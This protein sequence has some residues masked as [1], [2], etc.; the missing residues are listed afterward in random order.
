[1]VDTL[2]V[3]LLKIVILLNAVLIAVTYMVLL[4]RKVI[5]WVQS[6]LGPMR[7]G[8]YGAL[9]PIADAIKLMTKEDITPTRADRWV[10]TASPI[11]VMVPA[12]IVFAVIPFGPEVELFGRSVPL[13]ITDIN[14]GLLYIVSVASLGVYGII[15][16]G[17]SSNSKYPLLSSL[18][19]SAQLISYEVAVT[20]T[21]VSMILMAGTLSMVGIVE[22]QREAGLWFAFVQPVAFVIFFIGGLA[23]TNR[24]PFDLPEAEQELTGGFHTEYSGMRFALFFLAEYANMIVISCL[25]VTLFL[26]GWLRPF[27]SVEALSF[28]DLVPSWIWFLFKTFV[29]LYIFLWIRATL[30]RYRYDQLMR[31]GWKVLIPIAIGNVVVTG[32]AKVLL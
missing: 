25:A 27:P 5:A 26:G 24:A 23:E 19:A 20:M 15:L 13:Y 1:M 6:R 9:Q 3:P 14:V 4:E 12:L 10:F 31:L 8:P 22:S 16:A 7:V 29:F 32:I 2:V 30:P 28:L 17:W 11:I 18:R 21:L